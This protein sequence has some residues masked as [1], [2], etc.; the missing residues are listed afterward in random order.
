MNMMTKFLRP[1]VAVLLLAGASLLPAAIPPAE[2]LLPAD[3][4]AFV[5]APDFSV[6]RADSRTSPQLMFWN[7]AAMRPFRD[8]LVGKF[9]EKFLAP[10]EK[11]LGIKVDD[12]ISLPQGQLTFAVTANGSQGADDTPPGYVLLLDARDQ[13]GLLKTNLAML[14]KKWT[15][16]GRAVRTKD[17]QGLTFT[18]VPLTTNDFA[19]ILPHR[20]PVS[21][22]GQ[23]PKPE[24]PGDVYVTQ[25]QS[26]L[27]AVN[28][29]DLAGIIAAHLRGGGPPAIG[30]DSNFTADQ[31]AQFR[32]APVY[33]GWFNTARFF[34][35]LAKS[36]ENSD[37]SASPFEPHLPVAKLLAATGLEQLKSASFAV[38]EQ[39]DGTLATLHLTAPAGS[40]AG[41]LKI[42]ALPPKDA[43]IPAFVPADAT[44]FT[45]VRLDG[46]QT[47]ADLQKM[48]AAFSPQGLAGINAILDM[49]NT[50]AQ[51]KNP[52]FDLRSYLFDNLGDDYII[53]QKPPAGGT[54]ADLS[55]PP[56][57]FLLGT[58]KPDQVLDGIKTIASLSAPQADAPAPRDYRGHKIYTIARRAP[59]SADGS[60]ASPTP[61]YL[62][63]SSSSGYVAISRDAGILEE[64]LRSADG[65][66][67]PLRDTPGIAAAAARVGGMGGGMFSYENQRETMRSAFKV[68]KNSDGSDS[69]L[70]MFPPFVRDWT[71]FSLLPDYNTVAKYF[72]LTVMGASTDANGITLKVYSP[73]P[74]ELR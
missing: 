27:V 55:S 21:D 73:R 66:T 11:D 61:S 41:L 24:K 18:V 74:P 8:K 13:S 60:A 14:T 33:Y 20:P 40:R 34:K 63:L 30:D 28:S 1:G 4:L 43:G 6:L 56:S 71:D 59:S 70:R 47:W 38:R 72:Y 7:D 32:D 53:Y 67:R 10:M 22:M 49:A 3:T 23:T 36:D 64:F 45:R 19:A 26:L 39:P 37:P 50:F 51:Q 2:K 35:L 31:L 42:L 48:V 52:G 68:L 65:K 25:F 15:D 16:A 58:A 54:L 5:T 69:I 12:F 46:R 29:A 57:L 44:K 17:I 62:Y 9:K